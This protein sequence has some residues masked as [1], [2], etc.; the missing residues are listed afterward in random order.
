MKTFHIAAL[1][2]HPL[3]GGA[4]GSGRCP[5]HK[6]LVHWAYLFSKN[7]TLSWTMG[8]KK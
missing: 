8:M 4:S 7:K 5:E 3:E 2:H 6:N 1:A